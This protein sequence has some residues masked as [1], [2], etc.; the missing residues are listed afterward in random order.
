M[1]N[2]HDKHH[3]LQPSRQKPTPKEFQMDSKELSTGKTPP[4]KDILIYA[5]FGFFNNF[6]SRVLIFFSCETESKSNSGS[7]EWKIIGT[8]PF[9]EFP[10]EV[11]LQIFSFMSAQQ[12]CEMAKVCHFFKSLSESNEFWEP[13][14][15]R[16]KQRTVSL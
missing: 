15:R 6:L 14:F 13:L 7:F 10:Q 2:K 9:L 11:V 8:M 16:D 4:F 1:G 12:L 3:S 5:I